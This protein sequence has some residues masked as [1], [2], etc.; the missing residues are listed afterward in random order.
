MK[1][2]QLR[3]KFLEFF[4]KKGHVIFPSDN[5]KPDDE[6]V[7]FTSA[8]MNQFKPYFLGEKKDIVRAAS[9]QKCLRTGDLDNVGRT[10]YH[11]TFFE[12]LGNFSFGGYFKKEAIEFAWDF[13]TGELNI[14]EKDLW[15][16]VYEKDTQAFEIWKDY[17]GLPAEKIIKL[18][19][20]SN[21]WPANAPSNGPD[22]PCGP[23]SEIFFDQGANSGCGLKSCN[24]DCGCGR[25]VEVW[26]LVFTQFNRKG[27]DNLLALPQKNIDTGMGLERMACVLQG[28]RTNFEI[29][30]LA[31]VVE[32]VRSIIKKSS[33][34]GDSDK[35]L[36]YAIVDHARAATFAISD[37]IFPSNKEQGYVIRKIIKNALFKSGSLGNKEPFLYR[38]PEVFAEL[39]KGQYPEISQKKN[40]ISKIIMAE[41]K[42]YFSLLKDGKVYVDVI[43]GKL[44][45]AGKIVL[46]ADDVFYLYDTYGLPLGLIKELVRENGF[47]TDDS[48]FEILLKQQRERSRSS[49]MFDDN[50]FKTGGLSLKEKTKFSGYQK[51]S[52]KTDI[53]KIFVLGKEAKEISQGRQGLIVLSE[54]PFYAAGGGQLADTG[55]IKTKGGEFKV[56]EV[57]KV[58]D[59]FLHKGQVLKGK[60]GISKAQA[61]IDKQRR[62]ALARAHTATHLLQAAL[63]TVLGGHVAQQG[64][65]VDEDKFRFDFTHFQAL[66]SQEIQKVQDL[67]NRYIIDA[68]AVCKKN[69]SYEQAKKEGALAFFKDKYSS[70]VRVVSISD[71][72]KELCAGTHLDNTSEAGMFVIESES[73]ISSGVRRIEAL[74]GYK[75]YSFLKSM[76]ENEL[77]IAA[78][79]KCNPADLNSAL[80]KLIEETKSCKQDVSRLL[81]EL[82][83]FTAQKIIASNKKDINGVNFLAYIDNKKYSSLEGAFAVRALS[84][85]VR[86][87]LSSVFIFIVTKVEGK[88]KFFCSA[89]N[90]IIAKGFGCKKF[91][92]DFKEE[93]FLKGGGKDSLVQGVIET[94]ISGFSEKIEACFKQFTK[95]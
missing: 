7:L 18:G 36:F 24:P 41:E 3:D 29:D 8:G 53:V 95:K 72:S 49:S 48:G 4:K 38:L 40:D 51:D 13:V 46:A 35:G 70:K 68:C 43:M 45:K 87:H 57:F 22:G 80:Q 84:D 64:S 30:I 65:L 83:F 78:T 17:A 21:F 12:M 89:S 44:K 28:K 50:I 77:E 52:I 62:M 93:L 2:N 69:L 60:I 94:E 63:R 58:A 75:A 26:N 27:K 11:H 25:F 20:K 42:K 9:C 34:S 88:N 55:Y 14:K 33:S 39:M 74:V 85:A 79:L 31:P 32:E 90:D 10:A 54:T 73:S 37:G 1:S 23:C 86:K 59:A 5:L 6:S 76:Q 92:F 15:V 82:A 66:T 81:V 67:V 16:S 56:E 47:S 71:Y 19:E 61:S 91:V